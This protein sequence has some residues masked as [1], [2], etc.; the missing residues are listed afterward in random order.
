MIA[1]SSDRWKRDSTSTFTSSVLSLDYM[2]RVIDKLKNTGGNRLSTRK[3]YHLVWT[4]FNKFLVRLDSRPPDW[5]DR[6][7]LYVAFLVDQGRQSSTVKSYVSAIKHVLEM[8]RYE[9]NQS[10]LLLQTITRACRLEND[11]Y[12]TRF[13]IKIGL[14]EMILFETN[15]LFHDQP[16]LRV[17]YKTIFIISYYGLFRIGE[18]TFSDHQVKV[19]DVHVA[20]NKD[21]IMMI[22]RSSK[23][24][25]KE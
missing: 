4:N 13:P 20:D 3:N 8:D 16:Y 19:A 15:R 24:H 5:E 25:G 21:K 22:L 23:T 10:R 6:V 12:K 14:L 7:T 17:M 1:G 18:L 11:I 9:W 2:W